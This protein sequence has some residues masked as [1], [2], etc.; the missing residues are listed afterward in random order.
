[1]NKIFKYLKPYT[2]KVILV[3]VLVFFESIFQLVL[4]KMMAQIVDVGI[5]NGDMGYILRQGVLMLGASLLE[6]AMV[7]ISAYFAAKVAMDV[8]G[9]MREASFNKV[10]DFSLYEV[11]KL[12]S[13][14]LI[15]RIT[16][17]VLQ[18]QNVV[19]ILLRMVL[20]A[21]V[22]C[23]GG[24]IMTLMTDIYLSRILILSL[25]LLVLVIAITAK[26][27]IPLFTTMQ[28]KVDDMNK[29]IREKLV[30]LRIIRA[31]NK[32][33]YEQRRFE[34]K[35][36]DLTNVSIKVQL[37]MASLL[38]II[39]LIMNMSAVGIVYMSS[40]RI[41]TF[42]MQVGTITAFI[43]YVTLI[44]M[45]L[46]MMAM[47]FVM[48]P[49]AIVCAKRVDE[50]IMTDIAIK[51]NGKHAPVKDGEITFN[52]VSARYYGSD[53]DAITGISFTARKG[54]ITAIV[55]GTGSG[56]STI[57]NMIMRFYEATSGEILVDGNPIKDIDMEEL[58]RNIGYAPQKA[59]LFS[60]T[61]GSNVGFRGASEEQI[62]SAVKTAEA[63]SIL[64]QSDE[65]LNSPVAQGGTNF[66]GGQKQ[67]LCIARAI[68][69]PCKIY[70]FDDCFSALDY[71]TDAMVRKNLR[72]IFKDAVVIIVAQRI[73]TV[74]DADNIIML[75][76]GEI[77]GSGTHEEL[78]KNCDAYREIAES[79]SAMGGDI[80]EKE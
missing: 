77:I 37:I 17:D 50:I 32:N 12:G 28:V 48:L 25:P 73:S 27:A 19:F 53:N 59:V 54:E 34:E 21:P 22:M 78:L 30:G 76:D 49:R 16:N 35:N 10:T 66:S 13:A 47:I 1:M 44:L 42:S 68:A 51:D 64:E 3:I 20:L 24:I 67:R 26:K 46:T 74:K 29:V 4:P 31:F 6:I 72:P 43:E 57:L 65:G 14:S 69:V 60:G 7:L 58:R 18:V 2:G 9:D 63:S 52:N 33:D 61:I 55:G 79:Q 41:N 39:M 36:R 38:P 70:L 62:L 71:K 8:G 75:D 40:Y 80:N 15:T 23:V 45:S 5:V 56:K 11:D